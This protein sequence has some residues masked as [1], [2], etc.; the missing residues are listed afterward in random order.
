MSMSGFEPQSLQTSTTP[1]LSW[2]EGLTSNSSTA[3]LGH[4][5]ILHLSPDTPSGNSPQFNPY[6]ANL[7][8]P[9]PMPDNPDSEL[10]PNMAAGCC[11]AILR[12]DFKK[13]PQ[14]NMI[15]EEIC[16]EF[17]LLAVTEQIFIESGDYKKKILQLVH[18]A[19]LQL[20]CDPFEISNKFAVMVCMALFMLHTLLTLLSQFAHDIKSWRHKLKKHLLATIPPFYGAGMGTNRTTVQRN[21]EKALENGNFMFH[22]Y[23]VTVCF[24]FFFFIVLWNHWQPRS[25][26]LEHPVIA[27]MI[28]YT[29]RLKELCPA[30]R[31]PC[32]DQ[33]SKLESLSVQTLYTL[34]MVS[35][36]LCWST[37]IPHWTWIQIKYILNQYKTGA[38]AEPVQEFSHSKYADNWQQLYNVFNQ[39]SKK[40]DCIADWQ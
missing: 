15:F 11:K 24:F 4:L 33:R 23:D 39:W 29:F 6:C 16:S 25:G 37:S 32:E 21:I 31:M 9:T 17:Y 13:D 30:L 22:S 20:N 19:F 35:N 10:K 1:S 26:A 36:Q 8:T 7:K 3:L 34:M 27:A 14:L 5:S 40:V 28:N 12:K 18:H 2:Q 38:I